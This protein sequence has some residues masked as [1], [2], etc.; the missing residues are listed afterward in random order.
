MLCNSTQRN[1]TLQKSEPEPSTTN[2]PL[3]SMDEVFAVVEADQ[4][5]G[6]VSIDIRRDLLPSLILA[7]LSCP[8]R[9]RCNRAVRALG[10]QLNKVLPFIFGQTPVE[11]LIVN[12][13]PVVQFVV[14][15]GQDIDLTTK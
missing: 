8:M 1:A 10:W 13:Q 4:D 9:A 2:L 12:G 15:N 14:K 6:V 11:S 7:L 5:D 3:S